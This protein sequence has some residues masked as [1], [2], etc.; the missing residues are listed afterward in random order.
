M[1]DQVS[2]A[3]APAADDID[4][5]GTISVECV[6]ELEA[7]R[8]AIFA[9]TLDGEREL[10]RGEGFKIG[11]GRKSTADGE[12]SLLQ[13]EERTRRRD[14]AANEAGRL[15]A[16]VDKQRRIDRIHACMSHRVARFECR[17]GFSGVA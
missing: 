17:L 7:E 10:G 14:M 5:F 13:R 4:R 16:I 9:I 2:E 8:V 15:D 3:A 11:R 1:F 6:L 12:A